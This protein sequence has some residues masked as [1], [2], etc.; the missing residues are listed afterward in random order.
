MKFN[1]FIVFI[2]V[3]FVIGANFK[4]KASD[5]SKQ[6]YCGVS[7]LWDVRDYFLGFNPRFYAGCENYIPPKVRLLDGHALFAYLPPDA[8]DHLA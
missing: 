1:F 5:I 4:N 7:R 6:S 8:L 2:I 3:I